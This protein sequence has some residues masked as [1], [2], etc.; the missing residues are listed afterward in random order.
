MIVGA[1]HVKW[2]LSRWTPEMGV[3]RFQPQNKQAIESWRCSAFLVIPATSTFE[4][5]EASFVGSGRRERGL[6]KVQKTREI[7]GFRVL[8][9]VG[10]P[11][12][13]R[14][15]GRLAG[16]KALSRRGCFDSHG[17]GITWK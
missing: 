2:W 6:K 10:S 9:A 15:W 11:G 7:W 16:S 13:L 5:R 4:T 1:R 14:G 3:D 12:K 8:K 17:L